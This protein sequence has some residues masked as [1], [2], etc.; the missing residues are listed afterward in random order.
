MSSGNRL[1][2]SIHR[3]LAFTLIRL[4]QLIE[5]GYNSTLFSRFLLLLLTPLLAWC[6]GSSSSSQAGIEYK[7]SDNQIKDDECYIL[8]LPPQKKPIG[9]I[10][11]GRNAD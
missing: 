11:G 6:G 3:P 2:N 10:L 1:D 9:T 4:R 7:E 8:L 5:L